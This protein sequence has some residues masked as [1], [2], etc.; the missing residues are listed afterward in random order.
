[1][2]RHNMPRTVF[3]YNA[4]I[5]M[6]GFQGDVAAAEACYREAQAAG[7]LDVI[8]VSSLLGIYDHHEMVWGLGRNP[9]V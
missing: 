7:L 3:T 1:M 2:E 9:G 6:H 5:T 4:M 8:T